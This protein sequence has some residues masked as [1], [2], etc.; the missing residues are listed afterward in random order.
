M[1]TRAPF[2]WQAFA[3]AKPMPE[4]PPVTADGDHVVLVYIQFLFRA[5]GV[6]TNNLSGNWKVSNGPVLRHWE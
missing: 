3:R 2:E 4:P 1:R 6:L 5:L